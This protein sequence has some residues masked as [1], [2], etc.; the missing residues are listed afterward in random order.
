MSV[1]YAKKGR[2]APITPVV[3]PVCSPEEAMRDANWLD[4]GIFPPRAVE[5][6]GR[7]LGEL[8][9]MRC[10][11]D[12][13]NGGPTASSVPCQGCKVPAACVQT[14]RIRSVGSRHREPG[15][16]FRFGVIGAGGAAAVVMWAAT[17]A[18]QPT[19]V[20]APRWV[21][22]PRSVSGSCWPSASSTSFPSLSGKKRLA[23][24][25]QGH[26]RHPRREAR[27]RRVAPIKGDIAGGADDKPVRGIGADIG[28]DGKHRF[29]ELS[30]KFLA[31]IL[32]W[33]VEPLP[34]DVKD[35][36][37]RDR[38]FRWNGLL[39]LGGRSHGRSQHKC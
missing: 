8:E 15:M 5:E 26:A 12:P 1:E 10:S 20:R 35:V 29:P 3:A 24:R 9:G 23:L 28:R 7:G 17:P 16:R 34:Q 30:R 11:G 22:H 31:G 36:L 39:L 13:S 38:G 2:L 27:R 33:F 25:S 37:G 4:R 19:G 21:R 14:A 32:W 18:C 6:A